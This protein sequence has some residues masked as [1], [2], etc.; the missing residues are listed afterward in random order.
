MIAYRL[1][2]RAGTKSVASTQNF[3]I[4]SELIME[5]RA[6][7]FSKDRAN[8]CRYVA[9]NKT[10]EI[11]WTLSDFKI[12][13]HRELIINQAILISTEARANESLIASE[14]RTR[15]SVSDNNRNNIAKMHLN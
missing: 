5:K 13:I 2:A 15:F 1:E 11:R 4:E 3:Y 12:N 6:F 8:P 7:L 14:A 10:D 9:E